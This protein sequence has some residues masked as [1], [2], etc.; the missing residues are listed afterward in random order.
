MAIIP[1]ISNARSYFELIKAQGDPFV[2]L[3]ELPSPPRN[4]PF[5]EEEWLDF[6]GRPQDEKDGR[7]IWE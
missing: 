1:L 5:F 6:K 3:A 4:E 2:F 7:K